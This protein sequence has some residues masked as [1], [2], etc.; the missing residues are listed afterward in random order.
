MKGQLKNSKLT[1][2]DYFPMDKFTKG[3]IKQLALMEED[4]REDFLRQRQDTLDYED[5]LK[6]ITNIRHE[7]LAKKQTDLW[8][9]LMNF[10]AHV[11][12]WE[13]R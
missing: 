13:P 2:P 12:S 3:Q 6:K 1:D 7:A 5:T 4:E 8:D 11:Q 10:A 9:K